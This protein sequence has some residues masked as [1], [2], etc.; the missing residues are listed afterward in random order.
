M[1]FRYNQGLALCVSLL[2]GVLAL[3]W[4]PPVV[5]SDGRL[6][7]IHFVVVVDPHFSQL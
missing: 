4:Q 5:L 6:N 3:A 7:L 1:A 2:P